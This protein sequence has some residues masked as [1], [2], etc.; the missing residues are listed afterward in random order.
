MSSSSK[1]HDEIFVRGSAV[2]SLIF[3]IAN[4]LYSTVHHLVCFGSSKKIKPDSSWNV[5]KRFS[6]YST[7]QEY[8]C[9][10]GN[11]KYNQAIMLI[12]VHN[13]GKEGQCEVWGIYQNFANIIGATSVS[14]I[15][16]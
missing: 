11:I 6:I 13:M 10:Y 9:M 16:N 5:F 15:F 7:N 2:T 1:S 8:E 3:T 14:R 4:S 12:Q